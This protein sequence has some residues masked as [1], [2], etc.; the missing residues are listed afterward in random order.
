MK[1]LFFIASVGLLFSCNRG[2]CVCKYEIK[3]D[4]AGLGAFSDTTFIESTSYK[5][6]NIT[7]SEFRKACRESN[8]DIQEISQYIITDSEGNQVLILTDEQFKASC[9]MRH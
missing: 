7:Q 4:D 5:T 8:K 6:D 9:N 1:K 3:K 2:T